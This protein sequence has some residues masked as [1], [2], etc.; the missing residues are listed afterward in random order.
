MPQVKG[1]TKIEPDATEA[2][3]SHRLVLALKSKP[4]LTRTW[5]KK[6]FTAELRTAPLG[7]SIQGTIV[8]D[9]AGTPPS[10]PTS[11]YASPEALRTFRP[12]PRT[13]PTSPFQSTS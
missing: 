4:T 10:R 6:T 13:A 8:E 11:L 3:L 7:D 1:D 5:E 2:R 9:L 12:L